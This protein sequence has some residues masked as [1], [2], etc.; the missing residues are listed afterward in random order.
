MGGQFLDQINKQVGK[1]VINSFNSVDV[2][3]YIQDIEIGVFLCN[4][5]TS[6]HGCD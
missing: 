3:T 6:I 4:L 2:G 1:I 5:N